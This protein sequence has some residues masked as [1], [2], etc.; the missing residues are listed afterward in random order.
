MNTEQT[1]PILISVNDKE[2]DLNSFDNNERLILDRIN[3]S[4]AIIDIA[5]TSKAVLSNSLGESLEKPK[6]NEVV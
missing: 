6:T 3:L 4:Q 2:Y 1:A 5:N